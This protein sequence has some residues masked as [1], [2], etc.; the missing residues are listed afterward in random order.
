MNL[1]DIPVKKWFFL[2]TNANFF[3]V[4]SMTVALWYLRAS[5]TTI[6]QNIHPVLVLI[7]SF[8]ILKE[9]FYIRYIY[10]IICCF[11]GVLIIVLNETKIKLNN[12]VKITNTGRSIGLFFS[13]IDLFFISSARVANKIMVNNKVPISTQMYYVSICTMIYSSIYTLIFRGVC[14]K[15]G[16]LLLILMYLLHGIFFYL[17]NVALNS[18]L[19]YCPLSK[20]ILIQYLNIVY[21]FILSFIFLHGKI[22]FTDLLG[23]CFIIGFMLYNSYYPL[24]SK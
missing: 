3:G 12:I 14:L 17:S 8:L 15:S 20:I 6:I 10:G 16:F 11:I 21:I 22:F 5:T 2:R 24:P 7:M 4:A 9:K 13:T 23:A 19:K 18:A 1:K